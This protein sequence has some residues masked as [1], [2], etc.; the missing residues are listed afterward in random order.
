MKK[1]FLIH[2]IIFISLAWAVKSNCAQIPKPFGLEVGKTT[3]KEALDMIR[4]RKWEY[5]EYDKKGLDLVKEKSPQKGKNTFLYVVPKGLDGAKGIL[6][7]FSGESILDAVMVHL[8]PRMFEDVMDELDSKYE[9]VKKK[10]VEKGAYSPYPFALWQGGNTYVELQKLSRRRVRL[11]YVE[12]P[13]YEN[14]RDFLQKGRESF[15]PTP[16]KQTWINEL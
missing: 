2:A 16:P 13:L 7:F 14:Y 11:I 4:S 3:Y 15:W 8:Q 1:A 10:L 6:L 5:R 12:K 9:L